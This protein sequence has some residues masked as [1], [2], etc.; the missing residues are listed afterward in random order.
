MRYDRPSIERREGVL[1]LMTWGSGDICDKDL[2]NRP[3][4][5]WWCENR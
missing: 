1:G 4:L 3:R 5:E 2:S